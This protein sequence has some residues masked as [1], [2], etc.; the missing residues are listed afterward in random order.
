MKPATSMDRWGVRMLGAVLLCWVLAVGDGDS[1]TVRCAADASVRRVRVA[2]ID[3]PELRQAFGRRARQ[4]LV[5]QC[6]RQNAQLRVR[7]RDAFGRAVAEVR[8]R[9]ADVGTA[10]VEAGLAWVARGHAPPGDPLRTLEQRARQARVG[11]WAQ[12][13][14][15]PPWTY[16]HRSQ[17][18][19]ARP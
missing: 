19:R 16:R 11:L 15:T 17:R 8:C 13:R 5:A 4:R 3:A 18:P 10:Q 12:R 14:P 1:L 7:G 2:A 6:L 9:G